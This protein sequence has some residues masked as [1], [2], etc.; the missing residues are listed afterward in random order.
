VIASISVSGPTFRLSE[1]RIAEIIPP[2]VEAAAE[3]SHRL[4]WGQRP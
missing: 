2:L 1:A 3:V 4:G